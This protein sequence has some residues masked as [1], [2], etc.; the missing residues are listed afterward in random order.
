MEDTVL[1][2][3]GDQ[4]SRIPVTDFRA[5]L[6]GVRGFF[7]A[8]LAFMTGEHHRVRNFAVAEL[9]R[10]YGRPL[11]ATEIS[12]R[13][14]LPPARVGEILEDL[15]KNLFFLV[16]N[17]AG[18]VNWAFPVSAEQTPHRIRFSTGEQTYAA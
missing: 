5:G 18:A 16:R 6:S 10:N 3:R 2:G 15:E 9:P 14:A 8:R 4:L 7:D 1:I 13:L 11:P 12:R 17:D